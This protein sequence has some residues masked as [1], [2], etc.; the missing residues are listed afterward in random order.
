MSEEIDIATADGRARLRELAEAATPGPWEWWT[1]N[2]WRRLRNDCGRGVHSN[3]ALPTVGNDGQ[4]DIQVRP[5]DMAFIAAART[6]F[7]AALDALD[8]AERRIAELERERARD[9]D[10]MADIRRAA[11]LLKSS[12]DP[13]L[14]LAASTARV[15]EL[16]SRLEMAGCVTVKRTPKMERDL[17]ASTARLARLRD[18]VERARAMIPAGDWHDAARAALA[19]EGTDAV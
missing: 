18:L 16:E 2:S 1:S 13:V 12:K 10:A 5:E 14:Q 11:E 4:P 9:A 17:A 7:P 8:R 19:Q 15:A 3:V 6:Q